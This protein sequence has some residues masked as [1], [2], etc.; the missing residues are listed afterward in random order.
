MIT[1]LLAVVLCVAGPVADGAAAMDEGQLDDAI[2]VW[3]PVASAGGSGVVLYDL[4]LAWHLK[5][6]PARALAYWRAAGALRPR[7]ANIHHNL[8]VVRSELGGAVPVPVGPA[9]GWMGILSVTE[10]GLLGL[11]CTAVGSMGALAWRKGRSQAMGTVALMFAASGLVA[12]G[13]AVSGWR[14]QHPVL[15]VVAEAA[16]ARDAA[17]VQAGVRFSLPTGTELSELRRS[18]PFVLVEDGGGR[19][20]WVAGAAVFGGGGR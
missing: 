11:L 14:A 9:M 8:A 2:A 12:G 4:G 15:V 20:G 17:D 6:E 10:L 5:G 16:V 19:R 1:W 13:L 18:G 3:E 7:D